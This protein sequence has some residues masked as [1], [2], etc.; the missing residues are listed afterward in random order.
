M[1]EVLIVLAIIAIIAMMAIPSLYPIKVRGE[2][3]EAIELA[4]QLKSKITVIYQLSSTFPEDNEEAGLPEPE[5]LIGNFTELTTVEDGALHITLGKKIGEKIKGK[6]V[7]LQPITVIGSPS[8]PMS[9]ICGYSK[10]P[11][12]MQAAG[13]NKTDVERNLLPVRCR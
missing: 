4:D 1:I 11:E 6:I 13:E 3:S 5:F 12:G 9:W 2:I 7:T 10:V 8:S